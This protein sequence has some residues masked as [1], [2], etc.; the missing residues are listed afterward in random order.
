LHLDALHWRALH[1]ELTA[2][3]DAMQR[4]MVD[5]YRSRLYR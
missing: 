5:A 4:Q 1:E 3:E 2:I